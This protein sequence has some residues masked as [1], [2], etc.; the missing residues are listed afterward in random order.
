MAW[1]FLRT[2]KHPCYL[3]RFKFTLPGRRVQTRSLGWKHFG[4][5]PK[6]NSSPLKIRES[7]KGFPHLP[8]IHFSG[9]NSLLNFQL[10]F[11]WLVYHPAL[12]VLKGGGYSFHLIGDRS[13][14]LTA[15]SWWIGIIRRFGKKNTYRD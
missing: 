9:V 15:S 1:L 5:A 12:W 13:P 7:Q 6:F 8:S 10:P 4:T 11:G 3:Y 14:R 2:R